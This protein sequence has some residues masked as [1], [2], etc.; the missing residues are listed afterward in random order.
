M[1]ENRVVCHCQNV[2]LDDIKK[3]IAE[4]ATTLDAIKDATEAA[5]VCGGCED[6]IE[7]ILNEELNK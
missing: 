3:A 4:G 7:E 2:E 1:S 6:E 5:T